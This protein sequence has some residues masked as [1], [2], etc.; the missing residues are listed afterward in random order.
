MKGIVWLMQE[1]W[2]F[3]DFSAKVL[4]DG[5]YLVGIWIKSGPSGVVAKVGRQL[6]GVRCLRDHLWREKLEPRKCLI[7][8]HKGSCGDWRIAPGAGE[9]EQER[10]GRQEEERGV[11]SKAEN[12]PFVTVE[13][14]QRISKRRQIL[15]HV[16]LQAKRQGALVGMHAWPSR[17]QGLS[18]EAPL[19][20]CDHLP[21]NSLT[22]KIFEERPGARPPLTDKPRDLTPAPQ[23]S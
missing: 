6:Q 10:V 14:A 15:N 20:S 23:F 18:K 3:L 8:K 1:E 19:R 12:R 21:Q 7:S 13:H 5:H 4:S 11:I 2:W 17:L 16:P 9:G 22:P